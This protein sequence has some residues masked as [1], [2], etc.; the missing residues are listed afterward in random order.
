MTH[1]SHEIRELAQKS[2]STPWEIWPGGE[3]YSDGSGK[4]IGEADPDEAELI[5]YLVNHA[6]QIADLLEAGEKMVKSGNE[7][8]EGG[9]IDHTW[10]CR[11]THG[12]G[13][14]C[15]CVFKEFSDALDA[16]SSPAA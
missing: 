10:Y 3:I 9:G 8:G 12:T 15:D 16:L 7:L 1:I 14:G 6:D 13:L 5:V 4:Y 2:A 11:S